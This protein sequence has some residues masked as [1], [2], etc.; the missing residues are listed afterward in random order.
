[1]RGVFH[2]AKFALNLR[3]SKGLNRSGNSSYP[4]FSVV[5]GQNFKPFCL[6]LPQRLEPST[7]TATL[8]A[9]RGVLAHRI[10]ISSGSAGSRRLSQRTRRKMR[11]QFTVRGI[12]RVAVLK[13]RKSPDISAS[14]LM[15]M[16][17]PT[18]FERVT[19]AFGGQR[20]IQLS[21]GCVFSG[22]AF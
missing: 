12:A 21:Y 20:S 15:K 18:R 1:M 17:H 8:V 2:S 9:V 3:R 7:G 11:Q 19:F 5:Y 16:A 10:V 6:L 13:P 22:G 4:F 14:C